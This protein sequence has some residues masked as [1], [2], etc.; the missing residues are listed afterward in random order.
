MGKKIFKYL[1]HIFTWLFFLSLPY[2]LFFEDDSQVAALI[3][4]SPSYW[5]FCLS[6]GLLFYLNYFFLIPKFYLKKKYRQYATWVLLLFAIFY[7][8][9]PFYRMFRAYAT[10]LG[11]EINLRPPSQLKIDIMTCILFLIIVALGIALHALKQW[12]S[13]EKRALQAETEKATAELSFLKA[14]IN[15]HFLFNTLNNIY[16]LSIDN[17]PD[18]SDSIMK[19]SNLMRYITDDATKNFVPLPDEIASINDYIDLQSLRHSAKV[20]LN[21]SVSGEIEDKQIAPLILMTYIENAFKYGI[22]THEEAPI[23]IAITT[24]KNE[25]RFFCQNKIF[26]TARV[27]DRTG[28]GLLNTRQRLNYIYPNTHKLTI[29]NENN[30]YTVALALQV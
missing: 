22:S 30:L 18:T 10:I 24:D 11:N 7:V 9:K 2:I 1:L 28:I 17:H 23:T 8:L 4:F 12:R 25:I 5:I 26:S 16:S 19:L 27:K 29:T 3:F 13:T 14:Q 6:F 21:F 15:P 20:H